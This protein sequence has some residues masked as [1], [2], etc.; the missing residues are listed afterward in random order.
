MADGCWLSADLVWREACVS[1]AF[2][3][4]VARR[5]CRDGTVGC[6]PLALSVEGCQLIWLSVD[7]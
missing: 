3:A 5:A 4:L 2:A 6:W 7:G 1:R